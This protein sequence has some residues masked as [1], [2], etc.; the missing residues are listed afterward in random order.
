MKRK[1]SSLEFK[2]QGSRFKI[3]S[4]RFKVQSSRLG[5]GQGV[6]VGKTVQSLRFKVQDLPTD[7]YAG[8][9]HEGIN[10]LSAGRFKTVQ[11]SRF[12]VQGLPEC[13]GTGA[14]SCLRVVGFKAYSSKFKV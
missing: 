9:H 11:S 2:V 4:S 3:Q 6:K 14:R 10:R 1:S 13:F 7:L 5:F 12:K 8:V